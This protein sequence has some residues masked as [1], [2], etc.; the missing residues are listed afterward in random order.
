MNC[1]KC[2]EIFTDEND[3]LG[4]NYDSIKTYGLCCGCIDEIKSINASKSPLNRRYK[5]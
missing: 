2:T 5:D 4:F 3:E 1:E